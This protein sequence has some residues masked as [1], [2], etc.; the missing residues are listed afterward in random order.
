MKENSIIKGGGGGYFKMSLVLQHK[1]GEGSDIFSQD[2]VKKAE[3][4]VLAIRYLLNQGKLEKTAEITFRDDEK[5]PHTYM[6]TKK[7]KTKLLD[8]F[9][10]FLTDNDNLDVHSKAKIGYVV[11]EEYL[12]QRTDI[13][14]KHSEIMQ[15]EHQSSFFLKRRKAE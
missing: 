2:K 8:G 7:N 9:Y 4:R 15:D 14:Q 3:L 11:S 13:K 12:I 1:I 5:K 10:V 6:I